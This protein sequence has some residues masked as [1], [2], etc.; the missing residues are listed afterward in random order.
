MTAR[1]TCKPWCDDHQSVGEDTCYTTF[2]IYDDGE[3]EKV[4]PP[5]GSFAALGRGLLPAE[6]SW[7]NFV[8]NQEEEAE[9]P[10]ML[11]EFYEAGERTA[12]STLELD[13]DGLREIHSSLDIVLRKFP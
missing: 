2:V 12:S 5:E 11:L 4:E 10:S 1:P 9:N 7:I 3:E 8:A 13:A 6:I